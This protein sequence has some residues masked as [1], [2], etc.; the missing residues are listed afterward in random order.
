M[1]FQGYQKS[2][3]NVTLLEKIN[4]E[5]I[6]NLLD[7]CEIITDLLSEQHCS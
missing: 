7:Y 2:V 4:G 3:V 6:L 1:V 5:D